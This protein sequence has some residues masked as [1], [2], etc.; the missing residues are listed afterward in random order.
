MNRRTEILRLLTTVLIPVVVLLACA[1]TDT[2]VRQDGQ[3][4]YYTSIADAQAAATE[5]Q[6]IVVDF[7]TDW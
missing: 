3:A 5:G 4:P 2:A 6:Y 7:Y 1:K